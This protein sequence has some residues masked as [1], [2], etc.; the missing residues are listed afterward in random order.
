MKKK[1]RVLILFVIVIIFACAAM[2]Y[3]TNLSYPMECTIY[4]VDENG[5][6]LAQKATGETNASNPVF[7]VTS[8]EIEGYVLKDSGDAVVTYDMMEKYYPPSNYVRNGTATYTVVYAKAYT[9]TVKYVKQDGSTLFPDQ[10]VKGKAGDS[11]SIISPSYDGYTANITAISGKINEY[12]KAYTVTYYPK[13]YMVTYNANGGTGGI[14]YELKTHGTALT[15]SENV[16]TRSG[17]TFIGWSTSSSSTSAEY[18]AGGTYSKDQDISLYA[19]WSLKTYTVSYNANG[20]DYTPESDIKQHGISLTLTTQ[21]PYRKGYTFIGWALTPTATTAVYQPGGTYSLNQSN[22]LY[23]VWIKTY[24]V[25]YDANGGTGAPA[26]Q[27]KTAGVDLKLSDVIPQR[28]GYIFLG[29]N[30]TS[31]ATL[32]IYYAGNIYMNDSDMLLYAVWSK[33]AAATYTISYDAN[34]GTNAPA[35]QTK[36]TDRTLI[37][38]TDIP[39]REGYIFAGWSTEPEGTVVYM[40]GDSY[41]DNQSITLYA[42]WAVGA[43]TITYRANSGTGAPEPQIKYHDVPLV[44]SSQEPTRSGYSFIGWSENANDNYYE[45]RPG[46][47]FE[48]NR[49]VTLYAIWIKINYNFSVSSLNVAPEEVYQYDTVT[50]SLTTGNTDRV[51]FYYN[52]PLTVLLNGSVIY[53]ESLNYSLHEIKYITFDLYVG[54]LEGVQT[55]EARINWDDRNNEIIKIDNSVSTTFE[56]KKKELQ[57]SVSHVEPNADYIEGNEVISSFLISNDGASDVTPSS[58]LGFNFEV[59]RLDESG[60]KVVLESQVWDNI[61]IPADGT[62]LVYFKWTIPE[63][64]AG[65]VIWC[66]GYVNDSSDIFSMTL[67]SKDFSQTPNTRYESQVPSGYTNLSAPEET[68]GSASW[69]QWEYIAGEFVLKSYGIQVSGAPVVT[70]DSSCRTAVY[71]NGKW[72]MKSGYGITLIWTPEITAIDGYDIPETGSYT[73]VQKVSA[74]FPEY[75]YSAETEKY[76][77]LIEM[78]GTYMLEENPCADN[79]RIHFIPVYVS[80]GNYTVLVTAEQIWTPAGMITAVKNTNTVIIDGSIYDDFYIR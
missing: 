51:H 55:I 78:N 58:G 19:V 59:Y 56:V 12:D 65:T 74:F 16:P 31:D 68:A 38:T 25:T 20:G 53:E 4:Y 5:N 79:R 80:N 47:V 14:E 42:V 72:T 29:W 17:Y 1:T 52:I 70:P 66:R 73:D 3:S 24:T 7:N 44:M 27:T 37:L 15:L 21:K 22:I 2:I 18:K 57:L 61:I 40:P 76:R 26:A 28:E 64:S 36:N 32:P 8:P 6:T 45:Y 39:E 67:E 9:V 75:G 13:I 49:S 77:T 60:E 41:E 50:V 46:D 34:G 48:L 71:E 33:P 62:N 11:Y 35:P 54:D 10:I 30:Y 43:Y 63:N 23:A 69:N